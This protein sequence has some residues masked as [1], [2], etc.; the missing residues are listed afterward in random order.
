MAAKSLVDLP[1]VGTLVAGYSV[2]GITVFFQKMTELMKGVRWL[3]DA[4]QFEGMWYQVGVKTGSKW[5]MTA[6]FKTIEKLGW[7]QKDMPESTEKK[8]LG[9]TVEMVE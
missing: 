2:G 1:K 7:E 6:E 4:E 5:K 9:F 8:T 3:H